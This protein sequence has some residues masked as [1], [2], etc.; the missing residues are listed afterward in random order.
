MRIATW[1]INGIRAVH[2][3]NLLVPFVE[4]YKPD[5]ICFQEVKARSEQSEVDLPDYQEHWNSAQKPGYAGTAIFSKQEPL[6]ILR[7][8]PPGIVS[9]YKLKDSFG[10]TNAEGRVI[11][12][13]YA[14][15]YIVNVYTPNSKGGLER[16]PLRHQH[17]D[18]A[19]LAFIKQLEN[20]KPVIFCGDL[21][22]AH[23]PDDLENPKANEGDHGYT[24]EE[25]EGV[26]KMLQ[27]GFVDVF[28]EFTTGNGHY[29]WWSNFSKARSRNV[30]W[31]IDYFFVSKA[32]AKKVTA[33]TIEPAVMGSDHC[34]VVLDISL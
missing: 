12:A 14:K 15:F 11:A 23:K 21:N 29:T 24:L 34:P 31:R 28:R 25:R 33:C 19:F 2:N 10:D 8:F 3:K 1:N 6:S 13:E 16:L 4:K 9:K 18:P 32:L 20:K 26:D 30:G 7:D 5:I 22:V 17:W 27:A